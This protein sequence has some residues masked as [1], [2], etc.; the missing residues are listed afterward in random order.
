MHRY[1]CSNKCLTSSNKKLLL[2]IYLIAGRLSEAGVFHGR[3][4]PAQPA[5][6]VALTNVRGYFAIA[7]YVHSAEFAGSHGALPHDS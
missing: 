5:P 6:V 3:P 4:T 1:Y 7:D 2:L